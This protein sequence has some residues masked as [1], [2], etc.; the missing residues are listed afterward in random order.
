MSGFYQRADSQSNNIVEYIEAVEKL[1]PREI[2]VVHAVAVG[3]TSRE[4]GKKLNISSRTVQRHRR[5][6][7]RELGITGYRGLFKW[8]MGYVKKSKQGDSLSTLCVVFYVGFAY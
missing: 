8:Y 2:E 3:R 5:N 4:I 1:S 6:I 7:C